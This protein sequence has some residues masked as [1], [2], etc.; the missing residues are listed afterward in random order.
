MRVVAATAALALIVGGC[1]TVPADATAEEIY[2]TSCARC[3]GSEL[4][5]GVGP[6][7]GAGSDVAEQGDEYIVTT[8]SRG[9]GRMP[10]FSGSLTDE[11]ILS[12]VDFLRE[13]QAG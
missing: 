13:Q 11:Q 4:Q 7:L 12:L 8:I 6:P 2:A 5:G 3:H 10:S 9:K 1:A